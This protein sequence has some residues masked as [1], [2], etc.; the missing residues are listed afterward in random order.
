MMINKDSIT[1]LILAGGRSSRMKG[2]DK[3]LI[4][5]NGKPMVSYIY[6]TVKKQVDKIFI[7]AN[8]NKEQYQKLV[9]Q[10]VIN[11]TVGDFY[12][13]LAGFY[14]GLKNCHTDYMLVLPC[15]CPFL[16]EEIIIR[17]IKSMEKKPQAEI[18]VAYDGDRMQPTVVLLKKNI[19]QS[20]LDFIK[21]DN[22]KIDTWYAQHN[23]VLA[24]CSDRKKLFQNF[25]LP[26][27]YAKHTCFLDI[28]KEYKP[29]IGFAGFSGSGKT[30]IIEKVIQKITYLGFN[31]ALIKHSHHNFDID[32]KGKDSFRFRIAGAQQVIVSSS[33]R[34]VLITEIKKEE[35]EP[36]VYDLVKKIDKNKIDIILVE[37]FKKYPIHKI[38]INR[39]ILKKSNLF[40]EDKNIIAVATDNISALK[41]HHIILDLNN[42]EEIAHFIL[43]YAKIK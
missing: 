29:I 33:V 40:V 21:S 14:Q 19:L 36:S 13:P 22:H 4:H 11:D 26:N 5:F 27:E 43:S 16:D 20:L 9:K 30:T 35:K 34:N 1:A 32:K 31:V 42:E 10:K 37:G 2:Q 38:E 6:D 3:G 39:P 25:N 41:T 18:S 7:S 17:L 24:D 12:G 8:R 23:V 15:D 28:E